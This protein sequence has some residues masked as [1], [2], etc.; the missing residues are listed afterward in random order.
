[1]FNRLFLNNTTQNLYLYQQTNFMLIV[2]VDGRGIE[3][4]LKELK[5]K[6]IKTKQ[7]KNLFDRKEFVKESV[8]KRKEIQKATYIQKL[9]SSN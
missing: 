1:M 7:N 6:V 5:S 8:K 2:N 4:A 3:K 9:K